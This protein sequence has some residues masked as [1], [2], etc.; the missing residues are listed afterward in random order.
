MAQ[1][2]PAR[3][4]VPLGL[5]AVAI[6]TWQLGWAGWLGWQSWVIIILFSLVVWRSYK[7]VRRDRQEKSISTDLQERRE[8]IAELRATMAEIE[9][10][11]DDVRAEILELPLDY[12]EQHYLSMKGNYQM[13]LNN[14]PDRTEGMFMA[15]SLY[16]GLHNPEFKRR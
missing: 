15:I 10:Q 8:S 4:G 1:Y 9:T 7:S 6:A 5:A 16:Y 14:Y 13:L 3:F 12:Y 11:V 2:I